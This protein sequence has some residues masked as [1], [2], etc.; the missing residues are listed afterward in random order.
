M[1]AAPITTRASLPPTSVVEATTRDGFTATV[2]VRTTV[3][4]LFGIDAL[5]PFADGVTLT[6]TSSARAN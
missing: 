6:A 5:L 4:P 3:H 1:K 2:M